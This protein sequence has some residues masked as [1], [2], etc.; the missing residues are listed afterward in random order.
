M[1]RLFILLAAAMMTAGAMAEGHLKFKGVE[2]NG[3]PQEFAKQLV[4]K[5]FE[6]LG[7]EKGTPFLKGNFAGYNDCM[8]MVFA[9]DGR[10]VSRVG[11]SFPVQSTWELLYNNYA[12]VK[13]MLTAKYDKPIN[14]VEEWQ[15]IEPHDDNSRMHE[16][17][18]NRLK[19][20]ANFAAP[21]GWITIEMFSSYMQCQVMLIYNDDIN[22]SAAIKQA[23][24]DL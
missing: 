8:I 2:I 21:N 13:E 22:N 17:K 3:T 16:L 18:M 23:I 12:M 14:D 5:G 19:M 9:R 11:V 7:D 6:Y 1:K 24:D 4:A 20:S 10:T 15:G